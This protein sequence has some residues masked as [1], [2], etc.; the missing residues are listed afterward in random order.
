MQAWSLCVADLS[1][2]ISLTPEIKLI[3]CGPTTNTIVIA[4][5][6][7]WLMFKAQRSGLGPN[8]QSLDNLGLLCIVECEDMEDLEDFIAQWIDLSICIFMSNQYCQITIE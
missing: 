8:V 5:Y 1:Y 6:L 7:A 2:F 4:N 3:L